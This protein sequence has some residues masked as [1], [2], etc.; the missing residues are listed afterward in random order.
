M[1]H[2][3]R[4]MKSDMLSIARVVFSYIYRIA[5]IG[6]WNSS[7]NGGFFLNAYSRSKESTTVDVYVSSTGG[8]VGASTRRG[9]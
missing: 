8:A 4:D 7:S 1:P 5:R 3:A 6:R 9:H 2:M